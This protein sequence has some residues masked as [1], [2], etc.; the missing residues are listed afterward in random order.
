MWARPKQNQAQNTSHQQVKKSLY[1]VK[2]QKK[3][4]IPEIKMNVGDKSLSHND[5]YL[6]ESA[7]NCV[8]LF[9]PAA[10]RSLKLFLLWITSL[11]TAEIQADVEADQVNLLI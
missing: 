7:S 8:A 4:D 1:E 6:L 11:W 3:I 10:L 9:P 2:C 5:E